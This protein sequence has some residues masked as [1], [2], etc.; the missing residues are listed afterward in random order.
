MSSLQRTTE[1]PATN[2]DRNH[3]Y[4]LVEGL[5]PSG[6]LVDNATI[7]VVNDALSLSISV[8]RWRRY[9]VTHAQF[10]AALFTN[11]FEIAQIEPAGIV[12]A[13]KIKHSVAFA[14]AGIT[15]YKLSVGFSDRLNGLCGDFDV[16]TAPSATN[17][18]YRALP[19]HAFSGSLPDDAVIGALALALTAT[20]VD[21]STVDNTYGQQENDVLTSARTQINALVT[22]LGPLATLRDH[23]ET[24]RDALAALLTP[25]ETGTRDHGTAKS[26]RVRASA[27][28]AQLSTSTAGAAEVWILVSAAQTPS[29]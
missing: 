3:F 24:L 21:A 26:V 2:C 19:Y 22:Q 5:K 12:H 13:C 10:Q 17:F 4:Q 23:T 9:T 25:P 11:D 16:D 18:A 6:D 20:A 28:G 15:D 7:R 1:L 8:P 29:S 27:T 14:G